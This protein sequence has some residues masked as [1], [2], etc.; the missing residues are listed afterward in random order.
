MKQR[1]VHA[2]YGFTRYTDEIVDRTDGCGPA[3]RATAC[4]P[5]PT[6]SRPRP[7]ARSATDPVLPAVMDTITLFNLDRSDFAAFLRSMRMDLTETSYDTY[8]D[9]LVYMEG[10]A[11]RSS[12]RWC[13]PSWAPGTA[14]RPGNR[15]A[16]SAWPSS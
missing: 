7:T 1:H 11:A 14:R 4:G 10:S 8:D 9:L 2:L 13:C 3:R 12:A 6:G 5:G 16:S 15:P